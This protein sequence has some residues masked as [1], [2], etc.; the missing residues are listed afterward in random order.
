M[1]SGR[2]HDEGR[3]GYR[4]EDGRDEDAGDRG[5]RRPGVSA[6]LV[7]GA[8]LL[9]GG[10]GAYWAATATGG[11]GSARPSAAREGGPA[12]LALSG[13][14]A[15]GAV[16]PGQEVR[17]T[18]ALPAGPRSA[19]VVRAQ[20]DVPREAAARLAAA[21]GVSGPVT[22]D[23]GLWRAG[24]R[25]QVS[26][27]APGGWA[28]VRTAA[29]T[30]CLPRPAGDAAS[31]ARI[32]YSPGQAGSPQGS[33]G[34]PV[35]A[36]EAKRVAAP[37]LAALGLGGASVDASRTAGPLRTVTADPV[38][39]GLPTHGWQTVLQ[40]GPDG[41]LSSGSGRLAA[42]AQGPAYPVVS[43]A[44]AV[45]VMR[46]RG[47]PGVGPC[48]YMYPGAVQGGGAG[49]ADPGDPLRPT[50]RPCVP[51]RPGPLE[52]RGARFGLSAQF[53]EGRP[54]LV[55]SWLFD[56]AAAGVPGT[57]TLARPAVDQRY[58]ASPG[59]STPA[60]RGGTASP[61]HDRQAG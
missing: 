26:Q 55:P 21:L 12:P 18:G 40:I 50:A 17:V 41:S 10:G 28:F 57:Y 6:A 61:A 19:H 3:A 22:A 32:C 30:G 7:A 37:V 43:A 60:G 35:S 39:E 48:R 44:E 59:P 51:T 38:V 42:L 11:G 13:W 58:I 56:A 8:V 1:G 23:H 53:V 16:Q 52:I 20:G 25:L 27:A 33:P 29:G 31:S 36:G 15:G 24:G 34:S 4:D 47:G 45:A 54:E 2:I 49:P 9:A 46:G 14:A 5:R